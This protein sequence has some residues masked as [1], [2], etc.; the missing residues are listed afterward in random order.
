MVSFQALNLGR[1]LS[2]KAGDPACWETLFPLLEFIK[3]ELRRLDARRGQPL[4][5]LILIL[6]TVSVEE[7]LRC[8]G[9]YENPANHVTVNDFVRH[10]RMRTRLWSLLRDA[11][12]AI[13]PKSLRANISPWMTVDETL[14]ETLR[15][16]R[17]WCADENVD[18]TPAVN[19][20]EDGSVKA[21]TS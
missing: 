2:G 1:S 9:T 10:E 3:A 6:H 11:N 15:I 7:V 21:S 18:W 17:R 4:L 5:A 14:T 19:L 16:L 8:Y 13:E 20:R 12:E